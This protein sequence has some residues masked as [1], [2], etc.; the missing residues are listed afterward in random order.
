LLNVKAHAA[1]SP[2]VF[3]LLQSLFSP[4]SNGQVWMSGV[5]VDQTVGGTLLGAYSDG[6]VKDIRDN[7]IVDME[8]QPSGAGLWRIVV[9]SQLFLETDPTNFAGASAPVEAASHDVNLGMMR[10]RQFGGRRRLPPPPP[11]PPEE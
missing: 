2:I 5:P 7:L 10:S 1:N 3:R 11:E 8:E 6:V 4:K 9:L